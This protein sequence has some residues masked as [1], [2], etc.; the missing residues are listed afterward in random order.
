MFEKFCTNETFCN[1][2][3]NE[4]LDFAEKHVDT[5]EFEK[6]NLKKMRKIAKDCCDILKVQKINQPERK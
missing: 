2:P 5:Y 1:N 3:T 4:E 6:Y